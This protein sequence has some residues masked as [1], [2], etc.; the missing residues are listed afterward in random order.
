[1]LIL[2][3]M[4]WQTLSGM[5]RVDAGR[6]SISCP[7]ICTEKNKAAAVKRSRPSLA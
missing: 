1:V 5:G 4:K 2:P 6:F 3:V 7:G